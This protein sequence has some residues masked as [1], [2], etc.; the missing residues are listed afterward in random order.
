MT[1]GASIDPLS[2]PQAALLDLTDD[3]RE[4]V[5]LRLAWSVIPIALPYMPAH[6][7]TPLLT[8]IPVTRFLLTDPLRI[9]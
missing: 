6:S 7:W 9:G 8:E 4:D 3:A 2:E 1:A 5:A